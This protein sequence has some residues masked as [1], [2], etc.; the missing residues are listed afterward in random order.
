MIWVRRIL[1][2]P[3]IIIFVL[4]FVLALLLCH[5][6]GTVGSAG[7]YNGQMH[8]AHVY[9]WV[10]DTMVPT[11]V[12]EAIDEAADE[13]PTGFP[14]DTP[15]IKNDIVTVAETA[16]PSEWLEGTFEGATKKIVPYV[17]GD[18][19]SFTI[20]IPVKERIDPLVASIDGVIDKHAS[21]FYEY[22]TE[23]LIV[24]QVTEQ[25][26][27]NEA[28]PYG[29]TLTNEEISGLVTEAM[30]QDWTIA[31]FKSMISRVADYVKGDVNNLSF[32]IVL[33]DV[34]S[35]AGVLI[36]DLADEKLE[37]AYESLPEC[38][39]AEFAAEIAGLPPNTLP[40]CRPTGCDYECFRQALE[41]HYGMTIA[42]AVDQNV[43]DMIP[44][45]FYFNDAQLR[46]MIGEDMTDALDS[47]R[48]FI[49]E[50]KC[51]LTDQDLRES[52]DGSNAA[53]EDSF[54]NARHVIHTIKMWIWVL[55]IL[56]I[57]L[58][59]AIGFLC[60]RNWK[61]RLLWPL[62]VLCVTSL[63]FLIVVAVANAVAPYP[64]RFVDRPEGSD[65]TQMGIAMTDK[66]DEIAHNAINTLVWGLEL[67][68]ILFMVFSALAIAGVIAWM[69]MDKRRQQ[70]LTQHDPDSPA[71]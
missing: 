47:A 8:K 3:L 21:E 29:I 45:A 30:P 42:E 36:T 61:S 70:K 39:P 1:A 66:A 51:Q 38:S 46:E 57:L 40:S 41:D 6:S 9:D 48:E 44:N 54:D 35:S 58:L 50:D 55:W 16:F 12:D 7:F 69:V 19:N 4:I 43:L 20:T 18:K 26:D 33:T 22:A 13:N 37:A 52:D 32:D 68:L 5:L 49:Y 65:A 17:V 62:C 56:A 31:Q 71:P 24:P 60:G 34:K 2:I 11:V 27:Q 67:K 14:I 63:I 28:L 59:V 15:A 64:D 10:Y 23:E 25:L 53:E